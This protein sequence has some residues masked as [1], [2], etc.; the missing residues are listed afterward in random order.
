MSVYH[1]VKDCTCMCLLHNK[2]T[3]S[4][5]TKMDIVACPNWT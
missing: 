5:K 1:G 2:I 4:C 3:Q